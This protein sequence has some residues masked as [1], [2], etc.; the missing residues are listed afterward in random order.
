MLCDTTYTLTLAKGAR[1]AYHLRH[2]YYH[3]TRSILSRK[4]PS[5]PLRRKRT[6]KLMCAPCA[7]STPAASASPTCPPLRCHLREST[8][9]SSNPRGEGTR[10]AIADGPPRVSV[11]A[12]WGERGTKTTPASRAGPSKTLDPPRAAYIRTARPSVRR[13][14]LRWR[15][16]GDVDT[17]FP[18]LSK[19]PV[20]NATPWCPPA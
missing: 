4:Q 7:R 9:P 6:K 10:T 16:V 12:Q 20:L 2:N 18:G 17:R 1:T 11:A 15:F 8:T 5:I 19:S 14:A 13:P 3:L